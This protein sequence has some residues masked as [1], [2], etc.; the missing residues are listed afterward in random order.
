MDL[1]I[2]RLRAQNSE[3]GPESGTKAW[4]DRKKKKEMNIDR[5]MDMDGWHL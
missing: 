1:K 3:R 5:W 2:R 4:V